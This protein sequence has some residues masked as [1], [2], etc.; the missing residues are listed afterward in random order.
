MRD[1]CIVW[2]LHLGGSKLT[3]PSGLIV[4]LYLSTSTIYTLFNLVM[5]LFT[6]EYSQ[7]TYSTLLEILLLMM[8]EL[9]LGSEFINIV[10]LTFQMRKVVYSSTVCV[11]WPRDSMSRAQLG[12][13]FQHWKSSS[14]F[15]LPIYSFFYFTV[16]GVKTGRQEWT[17]GGWMVEKE[18]IF[19]WIVWFWIFGKPSE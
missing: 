13:S 7:S 2:L 19:L 8:E 4:F 12:S 14:V 17:T 1:V 16:C 15:T 3:A 6:T 18:N 11:S 10:S 5:P 9:G